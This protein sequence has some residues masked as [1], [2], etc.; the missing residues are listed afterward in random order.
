[1]EKAQLL[2]REFIEGARGI[3]CPDKPRLLT[4]QETHFIVKNVCSELLELLSTTHEDPQH[5]FALAFAESER[6][7][8]TKP[9]SETDKDALIAEQADASVDLI[10][11][12]LDASSMASQ[13]LSPVFEEVNGANMR[14]KFPDGSFHLDENKKI[15][16]PP[17]FEPPDVTRIIKRHLEE[18]SWPDRKIPRTSDI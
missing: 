8:R 14:K 6:H 4:K 3:T 16:K 5:A 10:V 18:G 17:G 13:F 12:T 1:M 15:L 9:I 2:V 11:Y 7:Y